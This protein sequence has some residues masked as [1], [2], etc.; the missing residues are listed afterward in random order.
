MCESES[1]PKNWEC[2]LLIRVSGPI[3][4]HF[5]ENETIIERRYDNDM[6]PQKN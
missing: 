2:V 1:D 5:V 4:V 3:L 6:G